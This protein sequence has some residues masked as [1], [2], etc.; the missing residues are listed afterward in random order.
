MEVGRETVPVLVMQASL[1]GQLKDWSS[2]LH[3]ESTWAM[4]VSYYNIA[5]AEWEPLV[6]PVERLVDTVYKHQPWEL[7]IE[8]WMRSGE[9]RAMIDMSDEAMTNKAVASQQANKTITLSSAEPL[10]ITITR[11][12]M[13]VLTM[14]GN[15]FS[16][17]TETA[18]TTIRSKS[19]DDFAKKSF[20]AP[21]VLHNS[22]GLTAKLLLA[23]NNDF[24]VCLTD[25][26][27]TMNY[28]EV[29]L[30]AGARVPLRL[31]HA[32]LGQLKLNE[33]PPPLK[34]KVMIIEMDEELV[35]PV[36]RADKRYFPLGRGGGGASGTGDDSRHV[37]QVAAYEPRGLISDIVMRDAAVQIYL[38]S[39]LQVL[40]AGARG[41]G[42]F[43]LG[44]GGGGAS[45]TGDDSRHV[46][47]VAAYEPRG[48][49]S[50]IVMR[51]A[52]VQIYLRSVLQVLPAGARGRGCE[53]DGR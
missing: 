49:I 28:K 44:R 36:E 12:G 48:L 13:E 14:L 19:D 24:T 11:T 30:E 6:E 32:G 40:P 43:P 20:G 10:E 39:V 38:R 47:Q 31:R 8:M 27:T 21:Y 15:S 46:P 18:S 26:Q 52:A 35:I 41:R 16:P 23:E 1:E 22:T 3:M 37:P 42:Y 25:S 53:R 34:L 5:R 51:D 50:D 7:K 45:G 29:I 2:D 33:P 4:Q 9:Q 17:S